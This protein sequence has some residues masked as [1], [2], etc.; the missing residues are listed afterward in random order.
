MN[1]EELIQ[2]C[3][4]L[5]L[6]VLEESSELKLT[7]DVRRAF[8]YR[9]LR[10]IWDLGEDILEL[11]RT[12]QSSSSRIIIRTMLESLFSLVAATKHETF[13]VEKI[14]YEVEKNID[15]IRKMASSGDSSFETTIQELTEFAQK[16]R[17]EHGITTKTKWKV[18]KCA[19]A[20]ALD[21]FYI[22]HYHIYCQYSHA[23]AGGIISQEHQ[24]GVWYHYQTLIFIVLCATGNAIPIIGTKTPQEHVDKATELGEIGLKLIQ[25]GKFKEFDGCD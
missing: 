4:E 14:I 6:E 13:A 23:T 17:S 12:K 11:E 5:L 10:N 18:F 15:G 9:H 24:Y 7:P 3:F 16:L 19:E 21:P 22:H 2:K 25:A 1:P 20:A 8:V